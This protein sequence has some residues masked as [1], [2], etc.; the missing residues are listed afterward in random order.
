M[1]VAKKDLRSIYRFVYEND[2]KQAALKLLNDL[3]FTCDT[4]KTFP[5]RGHLPPELHNTSNKNFLE[6]H[7]KPYRIIYEILGEVVYIHA[8]LDGRRNIEDIL[9]ERMLR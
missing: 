7:F 1:I 5:S 3:Q 6:I 9:V 4:L 8:V 2:C